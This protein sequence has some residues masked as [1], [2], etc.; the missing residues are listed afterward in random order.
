MS[1][2]KGEGTTIILYGSTSVST[3]ARSHPGY[4]ARPDLIGEWPTVVL[5][6]PSYEAASSV[7]AIC[8]DIAR[9]GMAAVAPHAGGLAAFTNFITNPAG[10]WSNAQLGYAV[11]AFGDGSLTAIEESA[12]SPLV[13]S[14]V[15]VDPVIEDRAVALLSGVGVPILGCSGREAFDGVD[16]ARD[17]APQAEWVVYEGV[18]SQYW[19]INADE[20]VAVA[21]EDTADRVLE[22]LPRSLPPKL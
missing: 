14:L 19:N 21:A 6:S 16:A 3:G 17:A 22:F 10:T 1:V 5:V 13:T 8:R 7:N 9:H 20:Y 2:L 4:L 12:S 18:G 15:L 11:L